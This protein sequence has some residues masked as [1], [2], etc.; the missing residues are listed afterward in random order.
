MPISSGHNI[1]AD[2]AFLDKLSGNLL[3]ALQTKNVYEK[4]DIKIVGRLYEYNIL[5][6]F[7]KLFLSIFERVVYIV[8][9]Y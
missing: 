2:F 8:T 3:L 6:R 4:I 7:K 1:F 9:P 5:Q